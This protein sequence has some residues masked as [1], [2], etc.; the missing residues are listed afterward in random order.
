M[1]KLLFLIVI[2]AVLYFILRGLARAR[3]G[4]KPS[5]RPKIEQMVACAHCGINVPGSEALQ[6]DGRFYCSEEHHRLAR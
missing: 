1:T 2:G 5:P 4:K 6:A 3:N